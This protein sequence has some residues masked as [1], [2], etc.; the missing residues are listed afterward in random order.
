MLLNDDNVHRSLSV[1][2]KLNKN[3]KMSINQP[4]KVS[5]LSFPQYS[6]YLPEQAIGI[7]NFGMKR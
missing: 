1:N 6:Q 4:Y 5:K 7:V 3:E 2:I